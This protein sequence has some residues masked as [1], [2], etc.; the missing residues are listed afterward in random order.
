LLGAAMTVSD[1][2]GDGIADLLLG[3]YGL[4]TTSYDAGAA[5][6]VFGRTSGWPATATSIASLADGTQ[7]FRMDPVWGGYPNFG[8]AV[9]AGDVNGDGINDI[10]ITAGTNVGKAALVFGKKCGSGFSACT[11]NF[12]VNG[13]IMNGINGEEFDGPSSCLNSAAIGDVNGDGIADIA[14]GICN[15]S[16]GD[17]SN[18]GQTFVY[19][20]K[21][22]GWP[23][24]GVNLGGL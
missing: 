20:G 15:A 1:V 18:A 13:T 9:A 21:K 14:I 23:T 3:S 19:Y 2:N 12:V 6:V 8:Q 4:S 11:A 16:P 7:G 10:L 17:V 22:K 24:S 5:Y